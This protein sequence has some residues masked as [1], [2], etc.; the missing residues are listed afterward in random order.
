MVQE[1]NI[2]GS[3]LF[4]NKLQKGGK[5]FYEPYLF[6]TTTYPSTD[7]DG[8]SIMIKRDINVPLSMLR[9]DQTI[10]DD[11]AGVD[12]LQ[13]LTDELNK[14]KT[15]SKKTFTKSELTKKAKDAGYS[16]DEYFEIVK[17]KITVK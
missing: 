15:Q 17:D 16:Y 13:R 2:T 10:E 4:A 9:G 7:K 8:K 14:P 3:K 11:K 6:A 1:L 12:E 5:T